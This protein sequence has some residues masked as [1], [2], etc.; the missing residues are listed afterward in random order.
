MM[1]KKGIDH[2]VPASHPPAPQPETSV[3]RAVCPLFRHAASLLLI[4]PALLCAQPDPAELL[5]QSAD[6]V[7]QYKSYEIKS[8]VSV[9][10]RGGTVQSNLDMPSTV[11]VRRPDRLRVESKSQAGGVTIVSDGEHTW[12]LLTPLN[13]FIK[14]DAAA[15]PEEAAGKSGLVPKNLPDVG[16]FVKSVQLHGEEILKVGAD[17]IPCWI[18]QT[19]YDVIDLPDQGLVIHGGV[20]STWISKAHHVNLQTTFHASLKLAS[21]AAPVE[22][23]QSTRTTSLRFNLDFPDSVF[24]FNPPEG[25]K[26]TEDWTLPGVDKPDVIGQSAPDLKAKSVHGDDVD[27]AALHGKVVLLD[28]W[29]TWC[30]PCKRELPVLEKLHTEFHD[31]GLDVGGNQRRRRT[32][33]RARLRP[34]GGPAVSRG[35]ARQLARPGEHAFGERLPYGGADRSRRKNRLV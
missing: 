1:P 5:R 28:F 23:T 7:K 35:S 2:S 32:G 24:A 9:V 16:K 31:S 20:Q 4:G 29:T 11:S 6:A 21:L 3:D 34:I 33:R 19:I 27:L 15:A 17:R 22:M 25:A 30:V 18:V 13:E 8:T 10:M 12:I 26:Q 14:R